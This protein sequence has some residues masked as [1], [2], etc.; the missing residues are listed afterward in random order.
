[1]I[2]KFKNAFGK[3]CEN[4]IPITESNF[5][6]ARLKAKQ[7]LIDVIKAHVNKTENL[8]TGTVH[9]NPDVN[10]LTVDTPILFSGG[11]LAGQK[12]IDIEAGVIK[13][14]LKEW[15]KNFPGKEK[16]FF[17]I[18]GQGEAIETE[19]LKKLPSELGDDAGRVMFHEAFQADFY[20]LG[21]TGSDGF[22]MPSWHEPC[23]LSQ[24][25]ALAK[26]VPVVA[27]DVGGLHDTITDGIDGFLAK[28][29]I[30]KPSTAEKFEEALSSNINVFTDA[31]KRFL[32]IF[33]DDKAKFKDM[34]L[35]AHK[36]DLSWDQG[37]GKGP[38]WKYL[39]VMNVKLPQ[40]PA[41]TLI[42]VN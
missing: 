30:P 16:P 17:I 33:Y 3:H 15:D 8:L 2:T 21:M 34:A 28:N 4:M 24:G 22:L 37:W 36:K 27:N 13:N 5:D 25:E 12:G 26:G 23:G 7:A 38:I 32:K 11:R 40:A 14:I 18:K 35:N 29:I 10:K 9:G 42:K 1:M 31:T 20:N 6:E 19:I 41:E 39:K